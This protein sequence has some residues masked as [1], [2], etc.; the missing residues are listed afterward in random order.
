[1]PAITGPA[2]VAAALLVVA[3]ATKAVDPAT[4]VGALRALRLPAS[5][6]AV[7]A[8][9]AGE[10]ALGAAAVVVGGSAWWS[11]VAAS[12]VRSPRSWWRRCGPER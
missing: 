1:M 11:L 12:Y 4:T 10:A 3:G 5:P 8:G 9:A 2:L 6:A 7:R